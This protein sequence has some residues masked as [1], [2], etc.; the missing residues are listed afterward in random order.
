MIA[1]ISFKPSG[2]IEASKDRTTYWFNRKG[3]DFMSQYEKVI[4]LIAGNAIVFKADKWG[5]VDSNWK[6]LVLP[7][8]YDRYHLKA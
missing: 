2:W 7:L 6:L 4:P 5:V 1:A 3:E 8:T